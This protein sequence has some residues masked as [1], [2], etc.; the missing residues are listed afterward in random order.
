[1]FKKWIMLTCLVLSAAAGWSQQLSQEER[2]QRLKLNRGYFKQWDEWPNLR[3]KAITSGADV[4]VRPTVYEH[5]ISCVECPQSDAENDF[6]VEQAAR[7]ADLVVVGRVLSQISALTE[8]ESFVI[9][10]SQFLV[11]EAWADRRDVNHVEKR[12]GEE[13]TVLSPGGTVSANGHII[14]ASY[15]NR[16]E[17]R[18]GNRYILFLK[19]ITSSNSYVV[20]GLDG[21]DV[22]NRT[23]VPLHKTGRQPASKFLVDNTRFLD[24]LRSWSVKAV[25]EDGR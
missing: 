5:D 13:I 3:Q 18:T 24:A 2:V 12:V 20:T 1:M 7:H 6:S 8:K 14:D 9:T 19:Y 11:E 10:D 17:L 16:N 23:V 22:T 4:K 25:K 15:P 21:F